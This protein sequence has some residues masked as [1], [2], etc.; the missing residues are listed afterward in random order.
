MPD[1]AAVALELHRAVTRM[2]DALPADR[3]R[4]LVAVYVN[5]LSERDAAAALRWSRGRVR[6][7][8]AE[9]LAAVRD[10]LAVVKP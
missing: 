2:L 4:V 6:R 10:G 7:Q 8:L 9:A 3:R 5:G 1:E